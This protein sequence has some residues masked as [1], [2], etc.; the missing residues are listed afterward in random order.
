MVTILHWNQQKK[1][2]AA[3]E[4]IE[5]REEYDVLAIQEPHLNKRTKQPYCPRSS[6]YHLVYGGGR[7]A[8]YVNKRLPLSAW[9]PRTGDDW[10]GI[11]LR[12]GGELLSI[13]SVYSPCD[14]ISW[15]SP[16]QDL[17]NQSPTGRDIVAG[18]MNLHHPLWDR[19]GRTSRHVGHLLTLA[20]RWNLRLITPWGEPTRRQGRD[21]DSTIDHAW[22]TNT[23]GAQYLG[24]VSFTG[25]DHVAQLIK[26]NT[27][28]ETQSELLPGYSWSLM[29]RGL[30]AAEAQA[31]IQQPGS[32]NT[33]EELDKETDKLIANLRQIADRTV[34]R[35]KRS[36]GRAAAWWDIDCKR[37][38][39]LSRRAER[40]WRRNRTPGNQRQYKETQKAFQV[41]ASKASRRAWRNMVANASKNSKEIWALERWARLRG[42]LPIDPPKIPDLDTGDPLHPTARTHQEKAEVLVKRFFPEPAADTSTI[43]HRTWADHS[44]HPTTTLSQAVT[45]DDIQ[46]ILRGMAPSKAPGEDWLQTGF[47]KACGRPFRQAIATLAGDSFRLEYFPK[48]FRTAQVVVLRK[49]GKTVQQQRQ[50]DAW[51]PISLLSCVGKIIEAVFASDWLT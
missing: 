4:L 6:R 15:R 48:C 19:E 45:E 32:S 26:I 23:L 16:L 41:T 14:D 17:V 29:D 7:A 35:R 12:S 37:A 13:Y 44:F 9:M 47:L 28:R 51:R 43:A 2:I 50:A 27:T 5:G 8:I 36:N 25:S 18:D 22:V 3:R 46:Q 33:P 31:Y 11:Q 38:S 21:R 1:P 49:P 30:V 42:H 34:P 24:P 39:I 10:A 20:E 40:D